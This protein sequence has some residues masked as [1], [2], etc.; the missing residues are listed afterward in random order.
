[1]FFPGFTTYQ[2][3]SHPVNTRRRFDVVTTLFG[4]QLGRYKLKQRRVP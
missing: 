1:M 2:T 4:R 3:R